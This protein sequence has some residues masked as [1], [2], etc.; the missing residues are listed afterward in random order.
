MDNS[1]VWVA[2]NEI[3]EKMLLSKIRINKSLVEEA[4]SFDP[5]SLAEITDDCLRKYLVV[6]GQYMM[7]IQY[8][9]NTLDAL[10]AAWDKT[11][12]NQVMSVM[13]A[14]QNVQGKTITEKRAWIVN[15]DDQCKEYS[16]QYLVAEA[17]HV[18]MRNMGRSIE[19]YI[20][21]LKKE[22]DAR[23]YEKSRT[24]R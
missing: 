17:K 5:N 10:R 7:T 8:E 12:E 9:E 14:N 21:T 6:L 24:F 19:Q 18:I 23:E 4:L 1:E 2:I 22:V 11:L 13:T 20:N 3:S 16:A 15:N